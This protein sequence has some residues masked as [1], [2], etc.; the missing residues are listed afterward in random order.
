MLRPFVAAD[1]STDMTIYADPNNSGGYATTYIFRGV[2]GPTDKS[3]DKNYQCTDQTI[4]FANFYADAAA[5]AYSGI[6]A[7]GGFSFTAVAMS[8][9]F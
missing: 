9:L 5:G 8:I 1:P 2:F 6:Y 4:D 7:L 3:A